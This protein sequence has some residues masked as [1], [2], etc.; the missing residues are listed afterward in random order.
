MRMRSIRMHTHASKKKRIRQHTHAY[1]GALPLARMRYA[2]ALPLARMRM[3]AY[4][5]VC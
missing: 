2:S 4:A 1:A 3:R 5:D